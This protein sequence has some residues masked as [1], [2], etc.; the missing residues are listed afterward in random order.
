MVVELEEEEER[1][2][3]LVGFSNGKEPYRV[4]AKLDSFSEQVRYKF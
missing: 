3:R 1:E 2:K 4:L